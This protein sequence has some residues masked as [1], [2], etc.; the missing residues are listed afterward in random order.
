MD[1]G[2]AEDAVSAAGGLEPTLLAWSRA[3]RAWK[4]LV[5]FG[6]LHKVSSCG[7]G[8]KDHKEWSSARVSFAGPFH[9]LHKL[10]VTTF[11]D[12]SSL[13]FCNAFVNT[14]IFWVSNAAPQSQEQMLRLL[15]AAG[16]GI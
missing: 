16:D 9:Q 13:D 7:Q 2:Q 5:P 4:L 6:L 1:Y 12:P 15:C 3:G 8:E 14:I 10:L 11:V